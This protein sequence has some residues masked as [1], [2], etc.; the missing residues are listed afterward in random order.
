MNIINKLPKDMQYEIY[1]LL[2]L[3]ECKYCRIKYRSFHYY[4][5]NECYHKD[6]ERKIMEYFA[7]L[8]YIFI[9]SY[10]TMSLMAFYII[11]SLIAFKIFVFSLYI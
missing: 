1:N 11:I 7:H 9:C 4:C 5:S 8:L 3:N 6:V 2:P 10:F